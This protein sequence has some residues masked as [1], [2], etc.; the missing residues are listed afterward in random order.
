MY[1]VEGHEWR[2]VS[3]PR[4][5]G[6]EWHTI[7]VPCTIADDRACVLYVLVHCLAAEA[8]IYVYG[9]RG[10]GSEEAWIAGAEREGSIIRS[11]SDDADRQK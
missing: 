4:I 7:L 8:T 9:L 5:T 1:L 11:L 6:P 3:R 2:W 10:E